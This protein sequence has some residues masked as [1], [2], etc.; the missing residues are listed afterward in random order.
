MVGYYLKSIYVG[1][2]AV[3]KATQKCKAKILKAQEAK[4][5]LEIYLML[6]KET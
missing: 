6:S 2:G 4:M 1:Y 3:V 5:A